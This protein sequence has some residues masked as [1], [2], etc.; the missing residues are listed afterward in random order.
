[1]G[2]PL[3]PETKVGAFIN[4]VQLKKVEAPVDT[5]AV[6]AEPPV[7]SQDQ[8]VLAIEPTGAN[9]PP[10]FGIYMLLETFRWLEQQ[11]GL[12]AMERRNE[13]KIA[14]DRAI[15]LANTAAE[16]AYIRLQLDRLVEQ[17]TRAVLTSPP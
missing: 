3:N 13:A 12:A 17:P 16:A 2:D 9:T 14:F 7:V 1:M 8:G 10:T 15:A 6:P 11:G 5:A 4:P